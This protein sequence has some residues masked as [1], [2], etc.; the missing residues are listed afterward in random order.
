MHKRH[1]HDTTE[2]TSSV[3]AGVMKRP[4]KSEV[5]KQ[6]RGQSRE[7][8]GQESPPFLPSARARAEPMET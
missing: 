1:L 8:Q 6:I 7:I 3:H 5:A 2:L 4:K